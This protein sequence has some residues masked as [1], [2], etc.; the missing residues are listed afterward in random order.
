MTPMYGGVKFG[1]HLQNTR[2]LPIIYVA[3]YLAS[4]R[5]QI[6]RD[7]LQII[8]EQALLTTFP[9]VLTSMTLNDLEPPK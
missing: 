6:D 5:L 3:T 1:Y 2:F 7:L 4:E 9:V 8:V